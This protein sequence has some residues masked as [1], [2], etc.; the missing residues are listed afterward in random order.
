MEKI[1]LK[2]VPVDKKPKR[3]SVVVS[4]ETY[5]RVYELAHDL[6]MSM[7]ALVDKLLTEALAAVE[8]SD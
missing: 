6:N 7:E 4:P 1:I 3:S 2:R 5:V 8:I